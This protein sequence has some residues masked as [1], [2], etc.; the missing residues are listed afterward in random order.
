MLAVAA[1]Q[2]VLVVVVAA[3]TVAVV[4]VPIVALAF[5]SR[6]PLVFPIHWLVV[7]CCFAF[8]AGIFATHSFG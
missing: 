4:I 2:V 3:V 6:H 5:V 1:N 7:A 8:V